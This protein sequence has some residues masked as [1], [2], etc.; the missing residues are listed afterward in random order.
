M[1][2][3]Y[4][5]CRPSFS[6]QLS[7]PVTGTIR[8]SSQLPTAQDQLGKNVGYPN[9]L[10]AVSWVQC[11]QS[12]EGRWQPESQTSQLQDLRVQ[13]TPDFWTPPFENGQCFGIPARHGGFHLVSISFRVPRLILHFHKVFHGLSS[14][15]GSLLWKPQLVQYMLHLTRVTQVDPPLHHLHLEKSAAAGDQL[16]QKFQSEGSTKEDLGPR[17]RVRANVLT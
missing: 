14:Y 15:W 1:Y 7:L 16:Q 3:T 6:V 17:R 8:K 5:I 13:V 12:R 11:V 9:L 2:Q 10:E 4:C